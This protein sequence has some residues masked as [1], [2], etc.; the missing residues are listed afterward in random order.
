MKCYEFSP[1]KITLKYEKH[2]L[3]GYKQWTIVYEKCIRPV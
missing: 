1:S 3:S 2:L